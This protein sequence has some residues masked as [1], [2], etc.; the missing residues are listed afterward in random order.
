MSVDVRPFPEVVDAD[1]VGVDPPYDYFDYVGTG[2][3]RRRRRS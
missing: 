3:A 2:C 1:R